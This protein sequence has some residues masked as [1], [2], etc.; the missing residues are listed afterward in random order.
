M[1]PAKNFEKAIRLCRGEII[2]LCDQD[3]IWNPQ[4]LSR[5]LYIF[6]QNP[7]AIY[8][9]SDAEMV[10]EEAAPLAQKLWDAVGLRKSV[11]RFS[12]TG[13]LEILLRHNLIPGAAL[14]FRASYR[15]ILL[16]FPADWMHDYWIVLLGS[17]LS[18]GVPVNEPLFKYRRHAMQVCGWRK[19]TYLQVLKTSLRT[20]PEKSWKKLEQFQKLLKRI[21]SVSEF[22]LC[23][24]ECLKL[25]RD[26]ELH[27][28]RRAKIRSTTGVSR[29]A[30]LFSEVKT[31]RYS[32]YSDS[33]QS[34][35][36]DL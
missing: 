6:E 2:A 19:Q 34:I 10:D 12:G 26:K 8:A 29:I 11:G 27:L 20:D 14:A 4:K 35:V 16:P 24:P 13:Q 15:D 5:L 9:F 25:L 30:S 18:Y 36:R 22:A 1:G 21:D 7:N 17:T 28:S 32:R 31:G 33:W 23:H 3:D